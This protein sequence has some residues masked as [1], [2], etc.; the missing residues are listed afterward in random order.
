MSWRPLNLTE[1]LNQPCRRRNWGPWRL[2]PT[3]LVLFLPTPCN[4]TDDHS[5]GF[6]YYVPLENCLTS[7]QVLDWI[8]QVAGKTWITPPVIAG[9]VLAIDDVLQLQA[10]LCSWGAHKTI[11]EADVRRLVAR[12]T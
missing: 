1:F 12:A 9:L 2:D 5:E 10:N 3:S 7:A 6:K 11:T 8:A 4:D